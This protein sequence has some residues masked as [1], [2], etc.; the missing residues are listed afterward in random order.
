ASLSLRSLPLH[1]FQ[2]ASLETAGSNL[3][4]LVCAGEIGCTVSAARSAISAWNGICSTC[5]KPADETAT[6]SCSC[7][8]LTGE[9][10]SVKVSLAP[11]SCAFG[12]ERT[13]HHCAD[14]AS[15]SPPAQ[16]ATDSNPALVRQA[17]FCSRYDGGTSCRQ[18]A[19]TD[20]VQRRMC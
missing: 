2:A 11:P 13:P 3:E 4:V 8:T 5:C 18:R 15:M 9:P 14:I 7:K 17:S 6:R 1:I 10:R 20:S 19:H 16:D 12:A